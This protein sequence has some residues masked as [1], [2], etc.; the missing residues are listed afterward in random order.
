MP[1]T[2]QLRCSEEITTRPTLQE[3]RCDSTEKGEIPKYHKAQQ[4]YINVCY[5]RDGYQW[6][7]SASFT[8]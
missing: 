2:L 7:R 3:T 8:G 1:D 6:L 5:H 4:A